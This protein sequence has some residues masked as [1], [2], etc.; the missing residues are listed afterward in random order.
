MKY[1]QTY[2]LVQLRALKTMEN[3]GKF[4]GKIEY[5]EVC[6]SMAIYT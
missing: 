3:Y 4:R 5:M 6:Q 1:T 2:Q